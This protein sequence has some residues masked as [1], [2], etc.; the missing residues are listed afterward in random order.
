ML[1][2]WPLKGGISA[3]MTALEIALSDG[4]TRKMIVRR[5]G[6]WAV[7]KHPDLCV[8]DFITLNLVRP[9][10]L[11]APEPLYLDETREIF[12]EPYCVTEYIEGETAHHVKDPIPVAL[13]MAERLVKI[14]SIS[15]GSHDLSL[16]ERQSDRPAD[17][18]KIMP[19]RLN[20]ALGER[21]VREALGKVW[22][23][24]ELNP[25]TLLHGDFWPGNILWREGEIVGVLDWEECE[26]G[27]PLS[28]LAISRLDCY[29]AYGE[30]AMVALTD[31]YARLSGR[32]M[33]Q[34]PYWD[35][36]A[37]LRPMHAL[38]IW[39][40]GSAEIGRDDMTEEMMGNGL[41]WFIERALR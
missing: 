31:A 29:W 19:D 26:V 13:K 37:S 11:G 6:E 9:L 2:T 40:A 33:S 16:L 22:P 18:F 39:A 4:S 32:E 25:P 5:P 17:R 23:L 3:R 34:L 28:D 36:W 12:P 27:E 38:P 20:D 24:P 10:G 21:Q 15:P 14:H 7:E 8:T 35:L 41:K 1:T 30:D